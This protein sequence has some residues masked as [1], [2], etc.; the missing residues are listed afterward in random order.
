[1]APRRKRYTEEISKSAEYLRQALPL[2]SQQKAALH[3]V[4]Y[5]VWYEIVAGINPRLKAA[6]EERLKKGERLDE[7]S[8]DA[9]F[10]QFIAD[11]D[12]E[13]A[14]R[15]SASFERIMSD[16]AAS[17]NQAGSQAAEFSSKLENL[18][19]ELSRQDSVSNLSQEIS[20]LLDETRDMQ[21][22]VSHLQAR[23]LASN[24]E[25]EALKQEVSR[26]RE[27]AVSDALTGLANRKGLD[28]ELANCLACAIE[29]DT[30]PS[31]IMADIDHFKQVNDTYG[32][33]FGDKVI[34]AVAHVIQQNVKGKD[35]AARYGGEEFVVLLPDTPPEGA[36]KVAE[37]IRNAVENSRIKNAENG[38]VI[39]KVTLSFGVTS[40]RA[41]DTASSLIERADKALYQSKEKGRNRVTVAA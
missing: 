5:A 8:T 16:M 27:E 20:S 12:E 21:S 6:V 15:I 40:F 22:A 37:T 14:E 13:E 7:E 9:L 18:G 23:L 36:A 17:T 28:D 31:L 2:M 19:E 29:T 38:D 10:R 24:Q 32:H 39:G 11:M 35:T 3:P 4:S 1:M 25:I 33:L 34:R 26:A 30:H 41:G